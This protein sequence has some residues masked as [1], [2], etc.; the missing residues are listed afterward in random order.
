MEK[1]PVVR[2]VAEVDADGLCPDPESLAAWIDQGLR[3]AER[4]RLDAHLAG[5]DEC[6]SLV[7]QVI[8]IRAA[9]GADAPEAAA[10]AAVRRVRPSI[11]GWWGLTLAAVAGAILCISAVFG[12]EGPGSHTAE[13]RLADLAEAV[14][15]TRTVEARLIGGF[16]YRPLRAPLRSG[17]SAVPMDSWALWAAA[18]R[19]REVA[20]ANPSADN[21]HALGVAAL[22][23]GDFDRAV[24]ALR[25][26]AAVAVEPSG[27]LSDL[28]AAHLGRAGI[29][30]RPNDAIEALHAA[31]QALAADDALLEARF[32]LALS[33]QALHLDAQA[34]QAWQDYLVRDRASPWSGEARRHLDSLAR[35][36]GRSATHRTPP[37]PSATFG[38]DAAQRGVGEAKSQ[39]RLRGSRAGRPLVP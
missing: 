21:L 17:G 23:V 20:D 16:R 32:N 35:R 27:P 34:A 12:R 39:R 31:R 1:H 26:S 6:R 24:T 13:S 3:A 29:S 10:A 36:P 19:I 14:G 9:A 8:D 2:P 38:R 11:V 28:A 37:K 30:D 18:G 4:A 15:Q 7:A 25:T 5:C 33:L 22:V